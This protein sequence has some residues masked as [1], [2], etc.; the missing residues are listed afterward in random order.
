MI[1]LWSNPGWR[2]NFLDRRDAF[3]YTVE[4]IGMLCC[5]DSVARTLSMICANVI[6]LI[7]GQVP[8]GRIKANVAQW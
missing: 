4:A 5:P 3:A 6:W 7:L 1:R 2:H 8:F